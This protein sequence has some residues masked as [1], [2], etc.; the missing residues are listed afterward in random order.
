MGKS[1][2]GDFELGVKGENCYC[3]IPGEVGVDDNWSLGGAM[4]SHILEL[5]SLYFP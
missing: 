4:L 1:R 5:V 3:V 2:E